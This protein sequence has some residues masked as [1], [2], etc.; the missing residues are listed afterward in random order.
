MSTP[1][2]NSSTDSSGGTTRQ[3]R[4]AW[5]IHALTASGVLL[6]A[7]GLE[8][9]V[10]GHPRTAI[11]YLIAAMIV[12][13][14]D[15]PIARAAN[16]ADALP[17]MDG[18]ILDLVVDYLTC[19]MLPVAF[20]AYFHAFP[21]G[22]T[23]VLSAL[24]LFTAVLWFARTELMTEDHW[25]RGFPAIWNLVAPT[26]FLLRSPHWVNIVVTIGLCILTLTNVKFVHPMQVVERRVINIAVTV[27]W[28]AA[29]LVLT[30]TWTTT[31]LP[32]EIV[33]V[34]APAWYGY[35]TIERTMRGDP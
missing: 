35:I 19:V 29:M 21:P 32:L 20:M 4:L 30:L 9:V 22:W 33:L 28:L 12:D 2:P 14:I 23:V 6:G 7:A 34:A 5:A 1:R 18:N 26:F 10:R 27:L 3:I 15:G 24:I 11:I 17:G 25:F 31:Y 16:V 13:G 8:A